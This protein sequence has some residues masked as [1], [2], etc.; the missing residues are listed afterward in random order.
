MK[1]IILIVLF[2]VVSLQTVKSQ[3]ASPKD[4]KE[5]AR[6]GMILTSGAGNSADQKAE[7]QSIQGGLKNFLH[8]QTGALVHSVPLG[9]V[10]GYHL[11]V[12]MSL[13]YYSNGIRVDQ[14]SFP[15]GLGWSLNAGGFIARKLKGLPDE[16]ENGY[17]NKYNEIEKFL[18]L[19]ETQENEKKQFVDNVIDENIDGQSDIF[20]VSLPGINAFFT[21][22]SSGEVIT[23]PKQN[24]SISYNIVASKVVEFTLRTQDGTEYTFGDR[25]GRSIEQKKHRSLSVPLITNDKRLRI[26]EHSC[27]GLDGMGDIVYGDDYL[28]R[29]EPNQG[30][31]WAVPLAELG[32]ALINDYYEAVDEPELDYDNIKE[33]VG[34]LYNTKWYLSKITHPTNEIIYFNYEK[35]GKQVIAERPIVTKSYMDYMFNN[36]HDAPV[37][38]L[39]DPHYSVQEESIDE[40][41]TLYS[42]K[43]FY[44]QYE[45]INPDFT[46]VATSTGEDYYDLVPPTYCNKTLYFSPSYHYTLRSTDNYNVNIKSII[47]S[48]GQ[49]AQF[50][51]DTKSNYR[52]V[53]RSVRLYR[54]NELLTEFVID[55]EIITSS[56]LTSPD[57][58][59]FNII[60]ALVSQDLDL[61]A[62][63][64]SNVNSLNKYDIA[65]KNGILKDFVL[66]GLKPELYERLLLNRVILKTPESTQIVNEFVYNQPEKLP[67]SNSLLKNV[68]GFPLDEGA[69]SS[70]VETLVL[71]DYDANISSI[72]PIEAKSESDYDATIG[73]LSEVRNA[74]GG[75]NKFFFRKEHGARLNEVQQYSGMDPDE[76][77]IKINISNNN[78]HSSSLYAPIAPI[79][80]YKY[81]FHQVD[82]VDFSPYHLQGITSSSEYINDLGW[83]EN[84]I[85]QF[86][87]CKISY[88]GNGSET[89]TF[90]T[91]NDI[92]NISSDNKVHMIPAEL[93]KDQ[94]DVDTQEFGVSE[95]KSIVDNY[96]KFPFANI[97]SFGF[98]M[99]D[100]KEHQIFAENASV[101]VSRTVYNYDYHTDSDKLEKSKSVIG[102]KMMFGYYHDVHCDIKIGGWCVSG[103]ID[104]VKSKE[105]Y[106]VGEYD[107]VAFSYHLKDVH[108]YDR[109]PI[110]DEEIVTVSESKIN[111][112]TLLNRRNISNLPNGEGTIQTITLYADDFANNSG[113]IGA[114]KDHNLK[115]L[116]IEQVSYKVDEE[117]NAFILDAQ[118]YIYVENNPLQILEQYHLELAEPMPL[119]DFLFA[120]ALSWGEV[121]DDSFVGI[122]ARYRGYIKT[123]IENKY[124]GLNRVFATKGEDEIWSGTIYDMYNNSQAAEVSNQELTISECVLHKEKTKNLSGTDFEDDLKTDITI[125]KTQT[126]TV[127]LELNAD[128]EDFYGFV[129]YVNGRSVDGGPWRQNTSIDIPLSP[130]VY[131]FNFKTNKSYEDQNL[132]NKS[133]KVHYKIDQFNA[134]FSS[135]EEDGIESENARTGDRYFDDIFDIPVSIDVPTDYLMSYWFYGD[136]EWRF[137]GEVP[138]QS[139]VNAGVPIDDL[140]VY[141]KGALV[142]GYV[143]DKKGLLIAEIDA[144]ENRVLNEYDEFNRLK[145]VRNTDEDIVRKYEYQIIHQ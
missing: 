115:T 101:P 109:D 85:Y 84:D 91:A 134:F 34:E 9:S 106:R 107:L 11:S 15:V 78:P 130:G 133:I 82:L 125:N 5:L 124:D 61:D 104:K 102:L 80:A 50:F 136:G 26:A 108:R 60:E 83:F 118:H 98:A 117:G 43:Y 10:D 121:P 88:E 42:P 18:A 114:L 46:S 128:H 123:N 141:K 64:I 20:Q 103:E 45:Y 1:R 65:F 127:E 48:A 57:Y 4:E 74:T 87:S 31:V 116:P 112:S 51:Y 122:Y 120:N 58:N 2:V 81:V 8:M 41:Y 38:T 79:S 21:I 23:Y 68:M 39:D 92:G 140:K 16:S 54:R 59:Y 113:F 3:T 36:L 6:P 40:I 66:D 24:L 70:N 100:I 129:L 77:P 145:I 63:E 131:E 138:F 71:N 143:Y 44:N 62:G 144:N 135:F 69:L 35:V 111:E 7:S 142:K 30:T 14:E 97:K 75:I 132:Y 32:G 99:G 76:T 105:R 90:T 12:P 28:R 89:F 22:S 17:L 139:S 47:S 94:Y 27:I 52:N 19:N 37:L 73:I 25:S 119:S 95:N 29:D 110:T 53:L 13:S 33:E 137:S 72:Q 126:V 56:H 67:R 55:S 93:F 86:S 96:N 49:K